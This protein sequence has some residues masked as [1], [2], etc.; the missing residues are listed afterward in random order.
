MVCLL[1]AT[2]WGGTKY[3]WS[4]GRII[5]LLILAILL[6]IAFVAVQIIW[7]NTAT[8]PP[9]IF[10]QRS[11]WTASFAIFATG[12]VMMTTFYYLPIWFQAIEGVSAVESGIRLLPMVIGQVLGS[13]A[14]GIGVQK[15]GYYTPIM[16]FSVVLMAVGSGLLTRL[17]VDIS[18]GKWIGYQIP[19]GIGLGATLQALLLAAQTVLPLEDVSIGTSLMFSTQLLGGSMFVSIGQ[20]LFNNYFTQ[21]LAGV[22]GVNVTTILQQGVTSITDIS[23]PTKTMVISAY[24]DALRKIFIAGLVMACLTFLGALGMEWK[25]VKKTPPEEDVESQDADLDAS[26]KVKDPTDVGRTIERNTVRLGACLAELGIDRIYGLAE[27]A[28]D[29]IPLRGKRK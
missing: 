8:V 21:D 18:E 5:A 29:S 10:A 16:L 13:L 14:G 12:A 3:A 9:L 23:E 17:Q 25:S 1:L 24:N 2:E 19:F 28:V 15:L 20:A 27:E 7:P 4:N 26:Q 11:I 22:A 6:L